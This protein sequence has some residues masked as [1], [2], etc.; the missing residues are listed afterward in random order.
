MFNDLI[1]AR[2]EQSPRTAKGEPTRFRVEKGKQIKEYERKGQV[3]R[4]KNRGVDF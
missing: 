2:P 3:K 1:D 4:N